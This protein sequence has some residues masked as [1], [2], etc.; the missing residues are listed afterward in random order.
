MGDQ[1]LQLREGVGKA[2]NI[3]TKKLSPL[4]FL[5]APVKPLIADHLLEKK[6]L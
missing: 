2:L 4:P 3:P 1:D 5:H 6:Y